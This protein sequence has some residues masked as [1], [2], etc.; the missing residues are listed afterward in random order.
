[1]SDFICYTEKKVFWSQIKIWVI[2]KR[3]LENPEFFKENWINDLCEYFKIN[4]R[5]LKKYLKYWYKKQKKGNIKNF[6]ITDSVEMQYLKDINKIVE[7]YNWFLD[8]QS[9]KLWQ[10]YLNNLRQ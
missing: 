8:N 1:M 3:F 6:Y 5:T 2:L 4:K 10:Y 7:K 9:I